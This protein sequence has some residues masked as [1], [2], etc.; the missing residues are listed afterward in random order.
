MW[1]A[2]EAPPPTPVWQTW[3]PTVL[4]AIIAA[5]I[6]AGATVVVKRMSRRLDE[7]TTSKTVAESRKAEAETV[8]VEVATARSLIAEIKAMMSEQ[9]AEFVERDTRRE[10]QLKELTTQVGENREQLR[11]VRAAFA[12]HSTWD[13]DAVAA[14]R[15]HLPSFP[16]PPPVTFD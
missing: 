11:A 13:G 12:A 2:G 14:L 7:A 9:R 1:W 4:G 5:L 8:S 3:L 10:E 16:D 6:A 15:Q